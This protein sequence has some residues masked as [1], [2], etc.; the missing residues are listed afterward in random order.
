MASTRFFFSS[1]ILLLSFLVIASAA[2]YSSTPT[3]ESVKPEDGSKYNPKP[4]PVNVRPDDHYSPAHKCKTAKPE[5]GHSPKP[6]PDN[7]KPDNDYSPKPKPEED[8]VNPDHYGYSPKPQ[9]E[10]EKLEDVYSPKPKPEEDN[11][12]ID[13]SVYGP[14]PESESETWKPVDGYTPKSKQD[15]VEL[16]GYGTKSK[17]DNLKPEDREYSSK[18]N[19]EQPKVTAPKP[20]TVKP[21][22]GL[23]PKPDTAKPGYGYGRRLENPLAIAIEGLVLCKSGSS[24]VPV[25]GAVARITCAA[26]DKNGNRT[27]PISCLTGA[28][29]A[30]GYFFKLLSV[31]GL[32]DD[33]IKLTDCKV[34]LEKSPLKTCN[35]ATDVNKGITGALISSYRILHDKKIK[36]YSVGPFFYT[37]GPEPKSSTTPTGY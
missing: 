35:V 31:L 24:Y 8:N 26:L 32:N 6:K 5:D 36:L 10:T 1:S 22:Y 14:K 20:E 30:K 19:V 11:V 29:D 34:Q 9:A 2:D 21:D 7:V 23:L 18:P 33:N 28:S 13:H 25:E 27:P 15:N 16:E 37:P 17:Q 3:P 4:E 12:K